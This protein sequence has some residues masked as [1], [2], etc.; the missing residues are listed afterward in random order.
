MG[1][2]RLLSV[3]LVVSLAA[4]SARAGGLSAGGDGLLQFGDV[5]AV[6][7]SGAEPG[8]AADADAAAA[9]PRVVV[10]LRRLLT[11]LKLRP[12]GQLRPVVRA[13]ATSWSV[14]IIQTF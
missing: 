12:P 2:R 13:F 5:P 11:V 4:G 7:Q 14:N 1:A 9:R 8:A 6:P 3:L 10:A